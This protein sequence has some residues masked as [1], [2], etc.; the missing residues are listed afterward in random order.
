[1]LAILLLLQCL[2]YDIN[3]PFEAQCNNSKENLVAPARI[4]PPK[5]QWRS[6]FG[7]PLASPIGVP[8][9]AITTSAGIAR[10]AQFGCDVIT[11]KT[12]RSH[13]VISHPLPNI[14]YVAC[15]H[16]LTLDDVGAFFYG[17]PNM[18]GS[19]DIIA[20]SNSLGNASPDP[21]WIMQDIARARAALHGGQI[22][23][24]SV[25]GEGHTHDAIAQDF[26]QTAALAYQA[27]AQIIEINLS[28]PNVAHITM[29]KDPELVACIVRA[30]CTA[31]PIPVTIKVG[32]FEDV[33]LLR[34]ILTVAAKAGAQGVCG[35]NSV[36]VKIIDQAGSAYFGSQRTTSGLSGTPIRELAKTF[37]KDARAII[38]QEKLNMILFATGGITTWQHF[39]EFLDAGADIALSATGIMW[40]PFI[41][42]NYHQYA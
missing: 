19:L 8:A 9:C 39:K 1:M 22:L 20:I 4:L 38:T 36:P 15:D 37:I 30:V 12:I 27:G 7:Y 21:D 42:S 25:F 13:R 28:C 40:N 23:I 41:V 18:Q 11:Y 32:I 35:I 17:Y 31:V 5:D 3:Q 33:A 10:L 6:L 34:T 16:Q 24:V 29:Y 2:L 14:C 26:A